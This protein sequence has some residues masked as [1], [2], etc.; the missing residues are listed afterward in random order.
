MIRPSPRWFDQ[1]AF[2]APGVWSVSVRAGW[3]G[4]VSSGMVAAV[5]AGSEEVEEAV[6]PGCDMTMRMEKKT[7]C[8][9][10]SAPPLCVTLSC[11][12]NDL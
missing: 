11:E 12:H 2:D 6:A 10:C 7:I 8:T 1:L 9:V 4:R 3:G 5:D